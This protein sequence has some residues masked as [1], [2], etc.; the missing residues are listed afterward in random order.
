MTTSTKRIS[1]VLPCIPHRTFDM[2][3]KCNLL[4]NGIQN[5]GV[6]NIYR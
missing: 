2:L 5:F 1:Y 4:I 3:L 6:E